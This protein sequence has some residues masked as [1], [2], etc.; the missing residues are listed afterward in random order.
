MVNE[1]FIMK[2]KNDYVFKKIFGDENNKD[3]LKAFLGAVLDENIREVFI[4]NSEITKENITDKKSI[5]DIR[6]TIDDGV[7]VI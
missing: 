6:A 5:L 4:L 2:P 1:E 3:I 7:Q